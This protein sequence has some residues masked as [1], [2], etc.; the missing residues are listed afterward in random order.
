MAQEESKPSA[1]TLLD[2]LKYLGDRA[3]VRIGTIYLGTM[4]ETLMGIQE[5]LRDLVQLAKNP[6]PEVLDR[7]E[8]GAAA[9]GVLNDEVKELRARIKGHDTELSTLTDLIQHTIT[10]LGEQS[11]LIVQLQEKINAQYGQ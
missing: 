8:S 11:R 1:D 3:G 9:V 2:D 7:L 6:E 4:L 5:T 10:N